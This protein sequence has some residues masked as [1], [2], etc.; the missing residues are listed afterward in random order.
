MTEHPVTPGELAAADGQDD[1]PTYFACR[2]VVYD[3]SASW[4]WRT[5]RHFFR[6]SAGT[7]LTSA[8][9][10]A[11]HSATLLERLPMV[12]ALQ[13]QPAGDGGDDP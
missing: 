8:L 1:R 5:G 11:P 7:D 3:A 2:G 6:H 13:D 10:Q 12:G 9:K 4:H